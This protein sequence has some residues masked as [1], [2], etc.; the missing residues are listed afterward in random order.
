MVGLSGNRPGHRLRRE[1]S[2]GRLSM[3]AAEMGVMAVL[4]ILMVP[5]AGFVSPTTSAAAP[6]REA[7]VEIAAL[8]GEEAISVEEVRR[9]VESVA[10]GRK[11]APALRPM[12]EAQVLEEIVARRL[13]MAYAKRTRTVVAP[14][15]VERAVQVRKR[16]T[17]GAAAGGGIDESRL[18]REIAWQLQWREYLDRYATEQR[19]KEYF[20]AH[21]RELDGTE[22]AVSHILFRPQEP[23]AEAT[24]ALIAEAE[25]LRAEIVGG[26][27]SFA[28]AAR[29][30]SQGPSAAEGGKLG[31]IGRHG[32]MV[33]AFSAAAFA[34]G[35]GEVSPPVVTPFGV[36]LIRCDEVHLGKKGLADA[37]DDVLSGLSR[38]LLAQLAAVE[39]RYTPVKYTGAAPY[40]DPATQRLAKGGPSG[41]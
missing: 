23:G 28:E 38:Q 32:P 31:R 22:L 19:L 11:L 36:H 6:D 17:G 3:A 29:R 33:E 8:V 26:S 41:R 1:A 7:D 20:E 9:M 34:L 25:R 35:P 21:R 16:S 30:H 4:A 5:A 13:V 39:R 27:V 40:I 10:G 37:H 15:E 2:T 18:R 12:A 14:E 24:E